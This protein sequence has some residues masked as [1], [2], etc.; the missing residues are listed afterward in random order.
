MAAGANAIGWSRRWKGEGRAGPRR[1]GM[2]MALVRHGLVGERGAASLQI[3]EDGSFN[4]LLGTSAPGTGAEAA[5]AAAAARVLSVPNNQVVP[6]AG[7][8][9]SAPFDPGAATPTLLLTGQAVEKASAL[10]RALLLAEGAR[11]LGVEVGELVTENGEVRAPD[12]RAVGYAALASDPLA[13]STPMSTTAF[14]AAAETLP[15]VAAVFAEVEVDLDT[16]EVRVVKVVSALDGGPWL[17]PR[18]AEARTEGD[19][20]RAVS[21]VLSAGGSPSTRPAGSSPA[22]CVTPRC[23]PRST[24]PRSGRS[25]SRWTRPRRPSAPVPWARPPRPASCS[26]L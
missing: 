15:A 9:N 5:F 21:D 7:D 4:L 19:A 8:T 1:R 14:H 3:R 11:R 17:D 20:L 10:L 12:A 22:R 6:A 24:P 25:S 18:L 16:G 2:G 26:R 23:P 13:S